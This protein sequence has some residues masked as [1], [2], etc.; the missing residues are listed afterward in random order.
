MSLCGLDWLPIGKLVTSKHCKGFPNVLASKESARKCRRHRR[1]GFDPWVRKILW[2]RK[3][4]TQL[5]YPCLGNPM[6]GGAWQATVQ[7]VAELDPIQRAHWLIRVYKG[8]WPE[9]HL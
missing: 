6:D 2:G 1:L 4:A 8:T 5:Q 9:L 7:G 3:L